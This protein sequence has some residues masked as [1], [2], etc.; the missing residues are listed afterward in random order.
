[1]PHDPRIFGLCACW[2]GYSQDMVATIRQFGTGDLVLVTNDDGIESAG[3]ASMARAL[4][5][6]G[7]RVIV[8]APA[9]NM[10]GAS[11]AIGPVGKTVK[12]ERCPIE[13]VTGECFAVAAPP[14]MI[15]IAAASGALGP[16]PTCVAAGVNAG[17]N[18]GRAILHSGTVGAALT[19]Q[20]LGLPAVA[21]SL[22]AGTEW[23][24]AATAGSGVLERLLDRE[25]PRVANVNAPKNITS[26]TPVR[27]T[28]L[29]RF[30]SVT[31]AIVG[32]ELAFQ[33]V[34]DPLELSDEGSD[35]A[36]ISHAEL[37]VTMLTGVGGFADF[38]TQFELERVHVQ[39]TTS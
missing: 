31:A 5:A 15:V 13:S 27:R 26:S 38:D 6:R 39:K 11:A 30:G 25:Q 24:A 3:V 33:L 29:S 21:V 18:L 14:A 17:A 22:E 20:N 35:G 2:L 23:D 1:M 36:A 28:T 19:A 7:A 9:R 4:V 34:I 10:S 16:K 8:A 12:I 32:E 37:S